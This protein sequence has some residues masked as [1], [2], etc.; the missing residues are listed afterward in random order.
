MEDFKR[1]IQDRAQKSIMQ[2]M[3]E[4]DQFNKALEAQEIAAKTAAVKDPNKDSGGLGD[5]F[6]N[7]MPQSK[8]A[9]QAPAAS[10]TAPAAQPSTTV[11]G[12]S[13]TA[14]TTQTASPGMLD[15]LKYKFGSR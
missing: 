9:A 2:Q 11:S 7:L 12:D 6:K 8:P 3:Q 15:F 14:A 10:A 1:Y 5:A 13:S 4:A